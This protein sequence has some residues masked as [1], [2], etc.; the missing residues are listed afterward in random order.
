MFVQNASAEFNSYPDDLRNIINIALAKENRE[1]L[2]SWERLR[3]TPTPLWDLPGLAAQLGVSRIQLKDESL[4]SDLGS[5]KVLG[6]P[7]ALLRLILRTKPE[8]HYVPAKLFAG[9]HANE[10]ADLVV[11]TATDGNHGTSLAAA[12]L[13]IGC[14]CVIVLH[15]LVSQ[16]REDVIASLGARIIRVKGNYDDSVKEAVRLAAENGW[17]VI[18]DTSSN[19]DETIPRDVMQG[20]SVIADE[21]LGQTEAHDDTPPFTH[22]FLQGGVGGFAAGISSYMHERYGANRPK[23]IVVEPRSADCLFQSAKHQTLMPATGSTHTVMAG[24][25][26]GEASPIA[27]RF[28]RHEIDAFIIVE[29]E[30]VQGAMQL[31]AKGADNDIPV[32][33]GESGVAGLVGLRTIANDAGLRA[34]IKLNNEA[35]V[36]LINTEG[37]TAPDIYAEMVGAKSEEI[38]QR[39]ND[40]QRKYSL[41]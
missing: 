21:M 10:L 5:F 13:A 6:A 16:E 32:V 1:W 8:A 36:L 20:Y 17:H 12:A 25:A 24:L 39:Q 41:A 14:E 31:L 26:C 4:R 27:W 7:I 38:R 35:R 40:W 34:Q 30:A 33:A 19:G 23:M 28:L 3:S 37:A 9:G 29:E 15:E 22:V 11:I 18:A 2:A